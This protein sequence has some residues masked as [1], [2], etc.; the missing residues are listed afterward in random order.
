MGNA[1]GD[2]GE[3]LVRAVHILAVGLA[4]TV[5]G[6]GE[7]RLHAAEQHQQ[8]QHAVEA[9]MA[10]RGTLLLLMMIM[11]MTMRITVVEAE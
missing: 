3:P 4:E 5:S 2:G 10:A 9:A 11:V 6:A 8:R 7:R 1:L